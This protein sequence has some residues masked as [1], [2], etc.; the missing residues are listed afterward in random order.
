VAVID[1]K[2]RFGGYIDFVAFVF[3]KNRRQSSR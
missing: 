2:G 1:L 3:F